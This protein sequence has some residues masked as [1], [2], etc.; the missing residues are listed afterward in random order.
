MENGLTVE[1]CR[2]LI[3]TG[4][5]TLSDEQVMGLRDFLITLADIVVDAY[6]DLSGL[7]QCM[8]N[9]PGDA[10]DLLNAEAMLKATT[11]SK[12]KQ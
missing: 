6:T 4:A 5:E 11:S 12:V 1:R 2:K 10:I 3:G 8:F 9:P 7:D